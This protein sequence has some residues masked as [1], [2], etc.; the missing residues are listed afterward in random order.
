[1]GV[2]FEWDP[3]KSQI[4][5]LKHGVRFEEAQTIFLDPRSIEVF[6][7]EYGANEDRF[8]RIGISSK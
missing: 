4:G 8:I 5:F 3:K 7:D 6:D 2:K 1:M